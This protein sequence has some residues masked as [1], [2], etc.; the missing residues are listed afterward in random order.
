LAGREFEIKP[1]GSYI[2]RDSSLSQIVLADPRISK[3]HVWL[4]VKDGNVVIT[5]QNSRNGTFVNDPKSAR[6][7]EIIL[8]PGD[9]VIL[10]ESDVAR[11]E[12]RR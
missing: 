5:D 4:G 7:N 1:E 10:G 3:R 2:G 8:K 6:V 12:Y 11:F 9:I